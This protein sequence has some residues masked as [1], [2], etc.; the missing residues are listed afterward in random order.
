M[1]N[2]NPVRSEIVKPPFKRSVESERLENY[3]S[4][5]DVGQIVS[6]EKVETLIGE[7]PRRGAGYAIV[8][9]VRER[10]VKAGAV[11]FV[12]PTVGLQRA[13]TA[14]ILEI[15]DTGMQSVKRKT[16]RTGRTLDV[17]ANEYQTLD[18]EG[19]HHFNFLMSCVGAL[20]YFFTRPAQKQLRNEVEN[21]DTSVDGKTVLRMFGESE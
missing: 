14:E 8:R 13:T 2:F 19:K 11:W 21:C 10:L 1:N 4:E 6:Y 12:L 17:A 16:V 5:L 15:S 20:T 3:L 18:D 7:N 9:G